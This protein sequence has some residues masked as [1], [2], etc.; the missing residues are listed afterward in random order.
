MMM[1]DYCNFLTPKD[2]FEVANSV[3]IGEHNK[4]MRGHLY[5]YKLSPILSFKVD[6]HRSGRVLVC[7][8]DHPTGIILEDITIRPV[9]RDRI[10]NKLI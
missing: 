8:G 6:P 9:I 5:A 7:T 4:Y 10:L 3:L 2:V 1:Q